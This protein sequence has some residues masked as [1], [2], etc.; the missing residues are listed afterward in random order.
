MSEKATPDTK[1]VVQQALHQISELK[2][3]IEAENSKKLTDK[4][5][6]IAQGLSMVQL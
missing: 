3:L 2:T 4:L 5:D 6:A 1:K